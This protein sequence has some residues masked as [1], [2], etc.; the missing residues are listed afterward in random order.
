ARRKCAFDQ[1][2]QHLP[3]DIAGRTDDGNFVRHCSIPS[4]TVW[5]KRPRLCVS[6]TARWCGGKVAESAC[7]LFAGRPAQANRCGPAVKSARNVAAQRVEIVDMEMGEMR[8]LAV[9]A[10]IG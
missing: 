7:G 1:N 6:I 10:D 9:A 3:S 2:A 4:M 5:A 8:A